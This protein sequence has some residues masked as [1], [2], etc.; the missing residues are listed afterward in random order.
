MFA[1]GHG[2]SEGKTDTAIPHSGASF[3]FDAALTGGD[4]ASGV[5]IPDAHLLF[6][7]DFK[8]AGLDL[9]LSD[10]ERRFVVPDYF[11]GEKH[12]TLM[13][14]DG[15]SLSGEVVDALTGHVDFAQ[16]GRGTGAAKTIG[17]VVKLTGSATAIR[18][19][20]AVELNIGDNVYKGDVV[21]SGSDSALGISFIDGTAFSLSSNARMVLNDMVY[22]PSGSSNRSLLSLVQGTISFV[23][24][25]TAK[26][27]NM[28]V[29]TP[30]ATMGIRGTAVLVEISADNGPTKFSVLV[31][32]G[33]RSGSYTLTDKVTGFRSE[34][35]P[36]PAL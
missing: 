10:S 31:E 2:E 6:S 29:D 7:G 26:N 14:P 17:T 30:V 36:S 19:G 24:G 5:V 32:P 28:R 35:S 21:Q 33:G 11:K 12:P 16:A 22:D 18:N 20:V 3:N 27:G 4:H 15:A 9:I 25:D 13:S 34:R 23:A 8:R 1:G